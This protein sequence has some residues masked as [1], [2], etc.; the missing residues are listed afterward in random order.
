MSGTAI[1]TNLL[2][3]ALNASVPEHEAARRFLDERRDDS[4]TVL[5][6]LVLVELYVLLRNPAV[7]SRPLDAPAA[8]SVIQRFRRH[9]SWRLIDHDPAVMDEVWVGAGRAGFARRRIFDLRLAKGLLR[10]G[11]TRFA[12]RN[13]ADFHGMG[14]AEVFDPLDGA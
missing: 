7:V 12:T 3:Y 8:A 2:L 13:V 1:D 9:P 5:S 6:E 4:D 14:F 10:H 11:V